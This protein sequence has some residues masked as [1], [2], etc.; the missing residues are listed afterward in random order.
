MKTIMLT[1][2]YF[3]QVDDEDFE[4][5]S[6]FKWHVAY[7]KKG[8]LYARRSGKRLAKKQR[9]VI[10]M[11]RF[12]IGLDHARHVDHIDLNGLNNQKKN[13]RI[14][15][16][17]DN[18]RHCRRNIGQSGF[19]GVSPHER[20]VPNLWRARIKANG[21]ER[22]IGYFPTASEAARAYDAEAVRLHGVFAVLNFPTQLAAALGG[23]DEA[24]GS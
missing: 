13:L 1:K 12:I 4:K 11:H 6:A 5:V 14:C 10:L 9:P 17:A 3:A 22:I 23:K 16:W 7:R 21:V 24:Q 18:T 20:H 2:G 15:S 8:V 19:R